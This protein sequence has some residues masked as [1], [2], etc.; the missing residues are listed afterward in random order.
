MDYKSADILAKLSGIIEDR[1]GADASSSYVASLFEKGTEKM[2]QKVG[3]E[4]VE[5]ALAAVL[6]GKVV[7]EAADLLFH[8]MILLRAKGYSLDD[9]AAEL[10]AREG[11]SGIDEK[12]NR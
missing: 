9:V 7:S 6:D 8:M 5:L 12:A 10:A 11:V 4:G 3:E 2:A 1:K